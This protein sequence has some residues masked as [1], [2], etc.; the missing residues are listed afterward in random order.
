MS[1]ESNQALI[2]AVSEQSREFSL[3]TSQSQAVP[4]LNKV[5]LLV[6]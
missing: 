1:L 2:L 3:N 6:K 4:Y 5:A